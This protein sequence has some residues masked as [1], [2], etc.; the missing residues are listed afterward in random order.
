MKIRIIFLVLINSLIFGSCVTTNV[1]SNSNENLAKEKGG[2]STLDLTA[3]LRKVAGLTIT[4]SGEQATFRVR[5]ITTAVSG[6]Q[7]LFI[8]N[9][10]TFVDYPSVYR[11]VNSNNFISAKVLKNPAET[12]FYG[13]RGSNGVVVIKLKN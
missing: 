11:L 6:N 4:G 9:G 10:M 2:T 8:V 5:G 3:Q 13:V 7:P 12:S 1:Q